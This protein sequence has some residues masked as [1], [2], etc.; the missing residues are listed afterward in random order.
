MTEVSVFFWQISD[1]SRPKE[2]F[3]QHDSTMFVIYQNQASKT[4][5]QANI[6]GFHYLPGVE[7]ALL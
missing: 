2:I 6:P 5:A 7:E 1:R 4:L 3:Y